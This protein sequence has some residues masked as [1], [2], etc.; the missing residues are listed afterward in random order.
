MIMV[1]WYCLLKWSIDIMNSSSSL[2][3]NI[4]KDNK[5]SY[6]TWAIDYAIDIMCFDLILVN[7]VMIWYYYGWYENDDMSVCSC[8]TLRVGYDMMCY[9]LF[10]RHNWY[11]VKVCVIEQIKS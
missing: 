8:S 4:D 9:A 6:S 7:D 5:I 10:D 11:F 2:I 3:I 1:Y